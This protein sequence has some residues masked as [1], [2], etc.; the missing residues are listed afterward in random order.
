MTI[1]VPAIIPHTKDQLEEEIKKVVGFATLIQVDISDGVF[2]PFKTWP[3]NGRDA[4]FFDRLLSQEVGWPKWIDVDIELHLMV[5]N[6]ET[7]LE[8]WISTGISGV[9]VHIESTEKMEHIIHICKSAD[10]SIGIAIKPMTDIVTLAPFIPDIDFIQCMGS[11]QLG[12]HGVELDTH[13]LEKISTLRKLYPER[14]IAVDIGVNEKTAEELIFAGA[15]KLVCGSAILDVSNPEEVFNV[16]KS[17]FK[18]R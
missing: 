14:I 2:T 9:V 5:K 3:Y 11:D 7:I 17:S 4:D 1:V 16:L 6:P 8:D 12:K 13:V 18:S 10:I 15:T